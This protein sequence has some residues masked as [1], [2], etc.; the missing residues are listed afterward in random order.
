MKV[1]NPQKSVGR[2]Q[3]LESDLH[4]VPALSLAVC[5]LGQVTLNLRASVSLPVK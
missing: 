2:T 4:L 5:S 3:I 1:E